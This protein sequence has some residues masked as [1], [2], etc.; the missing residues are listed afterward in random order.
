M[1]HILSNFFFRIELTYDTVKVDIAK[2]RHNRSVFYQ[3]TEAMIGEIQSDKSDRRHIEKRK[4]EREHFNQ[5][6]QDMH[7]FYENFLLLPR[8]RV[9]SSLLKERKLP[10]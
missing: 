2:A 9:I 8:I 5:T 10:F 3:A 4:E 6:Y 7:T 1:N